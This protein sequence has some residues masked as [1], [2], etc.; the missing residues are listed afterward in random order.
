MSKP[1]ISVYICT[2]KDEGELKKTL[3]TYGKSD[4]TS[5]DYTVKIINNYGKLILNDNFGF[6][7]EVVDN[8]TRPDFSGGHLAR[9]WNE[10]IIDGFKSVKE[11]ASDIVVC[12]QNDVNVLPDT[13]STLVEAHKKYNF[14]Q[15]GIG[16]AFCSYTIDCIKKVGLWDERYCNIGYQE[17]DYLT[18]NWLFNR[19][20]SSILNV[21]HRGRDDT[22]SPINRN[23]VLK[24]PIL[25]TS[26]PTG[27]KRKAD[28][29]AD[30]EKYHK[31]SRKIF[32]K[33]WGELFFKLRDS[34]TVRYPQNILY[35]YFEKDLGDMSK[36]GY[37]KYD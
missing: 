8:L 36:R 3:E 35:P 1:K 32:V 13:F 30:T 26:R 11:P 4:L 31:Y 15:G 5:F 17:M 37:I 33:K 12:S 34:L 2:Y 24:K 20:G 6:D 14:I 23:N 9:T 25:D 19:P 16:D 27:S 10:C 18:R 29:R 21:L 28:F 7:Y 22:K